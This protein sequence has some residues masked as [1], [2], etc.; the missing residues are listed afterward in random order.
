MSDIE[1]S[2]VIPT[3]NEEAN[4]FLLYKQITEV[5]TSMKKPYE[6]IFID[7]GSRDRTLPN[8]KS[9]KEKDSHVKIIVFRSNFGQTAALDAGFKNAKGKVLFAMDADLQNDPKDIP[10]LLKKLNEGYDCVSG[11]RFDR[12]DSFSK[13]IVSVFANILRKYLTK[14]NIHDSG[15]TLKAY[16]KECFNDLTLFGEMHRYIPAL[17]KWR[18]FKIG[19]LKVHHHARKFGKTKYGMLRVFRGFLDLLVV[20][21]WMQYSVRPIHFFGG[22]GLLMSA[23]GVIIGLYLTFVKYIMHIGIWGRPLLILA[24][25]LIILGAQLLIFGLL[26]DIMMKIYY[27]DVGNYSIREIL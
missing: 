2:V 27:R 15:C 16:R 11:W 18:G 7:D 25:L 22:M 6:I 3:Y 12:K 20:K 8:L 4:V 1:L 17:L 24:V 13:K 21:F 5:M 9:I 19:E 14:D 10:R 26:A 23:V